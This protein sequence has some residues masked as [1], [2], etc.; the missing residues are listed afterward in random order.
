MNEQASPDVSVIVPA[1]N[2][3][4]Y[5]GDAIDSVLEGDFE[6]VEVV[7]VNDGSTDETEDVIA[8]YTDSSRP[9]YDERVR[10]VS[11]P[12]QGKAGAVNNGLDLARGAYVTILDADDELTSDSLSA[13]YKYRT[14]EYGRQRDLVIGGFEVFDEDG[15]H[16]ERLPP[17]ADSETLRR[18]F[19]LRWK[20]PFSLNA[21]LISKRTIDRAGTLDERYR[22]CLDGDYA[23]RVLRVADRISVVQSVVYRYR[24][25]RTSRVERLRTRLRTARYRLRV[26]WKNYHGW[27]KWVALPFGLVMDAGKF[28]Y[29]LLIGNYKN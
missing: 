20:T 6:E 29:E 16:G 3:A 28:G 13:R 4:E 14:D 12:N 26:I 24:K 23:M 18:Q 2:M 27:R 11:Q 10:Y 15:T 19:Y 7:V 9:E 22:R 25:H 17:D 8:P 21:C 5:V 1:Y